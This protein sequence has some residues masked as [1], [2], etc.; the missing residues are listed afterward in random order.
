MLQYTIVGKTSRKNMINN[1]L[2]FLSIAIAP[3]LTN[4]YLDLKITLFYIILGAIALKNKT[5]ET[6][7]TSI[8]LSLL[9]F[10]I[11]AISTFYSKTKIQSL[12]GTFDNKIGS[13]IYFSLI[14]LYLLSQQ[15][16]SNEKN[17]KQFFEYLIKFS[18]IAS[19]YSLIQFLD[20]DP[21]INSIKE[22]SYR[23]FSF[24]GQPNFLGQF[25]LFPL[26]FLLLSSIKNF[27]KNLKYLIFVS[28]SFILTQNKASFLGLSYGIFAYILNKIKIKNKTKWLI[29]TT[30]I[31]PSAFLIYLNP[32]NFRSLFSREI[33]YSNLSSLISFNQILLGNG[34]NTFKDNFLKILPTQAFEFENLLSSPQNI[35][36]ELLQTFLDLGIVGLITIL[37]IY[38]SVIKNLFKKEDTYK[39]AIKYSIFAYFISMQFSFQSIEGYILLT[40]ALALYHSENIQIKINLNWS[41]YIIGTSLILFGIYNFIG[42]YQNLSIEK[43][44]FTSE[45]NIQKKLDSAFFFHKIYQYP[46][47]NAIKYSMVDNS[48]NSQK[49]KDQS[50]LIN[51][52]SVDYLNVQINLSQ[53][54]KDLKANTEKAIKLYPTSPLAYINAYYKYYDDFRNC[55]ESNYYKEELKKLLPKK[56]T[57]N[58]QNC[59]EINE[60]RL[61]LKHA[62][63]LDYIF[64]NKE[65]YCG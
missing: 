50:Y 19:I 41:K 16:Y 17:Q 14:F 64:N 12:F 32:L 65:N 20:L 40:L 54:E 11:I 58:I 29:L 39:T 53:N 24:F 30:S 47:N 10:C 45:E 8:M 27:K 48:L 9:Y 6:N 57:Q 23:P 46:L 21:L 37:S 7:K 38:F 61:F 31:V 5:I 44:F 25:L 36:N 1:K 2:L 28:T 60:C 3:F 62:Q 43:T 26:T 13:V 34:L 55:K 15:F 56:Y 49:Q 42:S 35:H 18:Y 52:N 63:S 22:I 33:L 59:N 4:T 51:P